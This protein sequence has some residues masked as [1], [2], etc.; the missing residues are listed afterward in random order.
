MDSRQVPV[1]PWHSLVPFLTNTGP[2]GGLPGGGADQQS[3]A[4]QENRDTAPL[5]LPDTGK[6]Q[7]SLPS[8]VLKLNE[9]HISKIQNS[10]KNNCPDLCFLPA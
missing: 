10:D 5:G 8:G 1:F 7:S 9:I 4:T 6:K 2:V 3:S